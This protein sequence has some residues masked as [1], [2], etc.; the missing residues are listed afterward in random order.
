MPSQTSEDGRIEAHPTYVPTCMTS[1]TDEEDASD[2][3]PRAGP[4]ACRS[5]PRISDRHRTVNASR[6]ERT[7]AAGAPHWIHGGM[8]HT[9]GV[10]PFPLFGYR[11]YFD[12]PGFMGALYGAGC[13]PSSYS[14]SPSETSFSISVAFVTCLWASKRARS[15]WASWMK[16]SRYTV[17]SIRSLR[18]RR[19][20][21]ATRRECAEGM[22]RGGR[23]RSER[24][25]G[26]CRPRQRTWKP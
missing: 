22:R 20:R 15:L 25:R 10:C 14:F 9:S 19:Y 5:S 7:D 16:R 13:F 12:P 3:S 18:A 2:G 24:K 1:L 6:A 8:A 21:R 17:Q 23:R 4:T 26:G 11:M